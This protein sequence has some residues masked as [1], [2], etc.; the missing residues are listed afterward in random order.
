MCTSLSL[1][2]IVLIR[3]L[4][5]IT[6]DTYALKIGYCVTISCRECLQ[7]VSLKSESR[8]YKRIKCWMVNLRDLHAHL[9]EQVCKIRQVLYFRSLPSVSLSPYISQVPRGVYVHKPSACSTT[10]LLLS[11]SS[12]DVVA[13]E[14]CP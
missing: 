3:Y 11:V 8:K 12:S 7:A 5:R 2:L 13:Q 6:C 1:S 10:V 9:S 14:F 4:L